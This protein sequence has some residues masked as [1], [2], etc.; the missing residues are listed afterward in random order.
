MKRLICIISVIF[1]SFQFTA[2][3]NNKNQSNK[4]KS[5]KTIEASK[6]KKKDFNRLQ[7]T[8]KKKTMTQKNSVKN[9]SPKI[10]SKKNKTI[11]KPKQ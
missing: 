5:S 4:E 9:L 10:E 6:L 8:T 1:I 7:V 2:Q 3:T 11:L